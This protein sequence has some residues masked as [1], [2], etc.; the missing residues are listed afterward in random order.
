MILES[1]YTLITLCGF[2]RAFLRYLITLFLLAATNNQ[3]LSGL[4]KKVKEMDTY[5]DTCEDDIYSV[6]SDL[7][8]NHKDDDDEVIPIKNSTHWF[9]SQER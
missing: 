6:I 3:L 7:S 9:K 1:K 8:I 4:R 2:G 5:S